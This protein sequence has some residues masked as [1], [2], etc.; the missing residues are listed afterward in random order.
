[1]SSLLACN[2]CMYRT[3]KL[4]LYVSHYKLHSN[5]PNLTIPC[6]F[7]KCSRCFRTY[8]ALKTHVTRYHDKLKNQTCSQ[9]CSD[10]SFCCSVLFCKQIC[11]S[12]DEF[13]R[14]IKDHIKSK[15]TITCPFNKCGKQFAGITV[16][17]F[18]SHV[19]RSHR[20]WTGTCIDVKY[21][22]N[23]DDSSLDKVNDPLS[24]SDEPQLDNYGT[25]ADFVSLDHSDDEVSA[26]PLTNNEMENLLL[27]KVALFT[28]KMQVK[29]H[30]P[31]SVVQ[32]IITELNDLVAV[33]TDAVCDKISKMVSDG[34]LS[35]DL[36]ND[37]IRCIASHPLSTTLDCNS[38]PLRS[39]YMRSAFYKQKFRYVE[40]V[41]ISLRGVDGCSRVFQYVPIKETLKVLFQDKNIQEYLQ[42]ISL[43]LFLKYG[44]LI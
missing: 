34:R 26:S 5:V 13:L 44:C 28:M 7:R 10:H 9:N 21:Y 33:N 25:S 31:S 15:T 36:A 29:H 22:L 40:P 27:E 8:G 39:E 11:S 38:G 35:Q 30:V 20:N 6:G 41:A 24:G 4:R 43:F 37:V 23:K 2:R 16:S 12:L 17:T 19:S 3:N 42:N 32:T 14:H 18:N 1:M